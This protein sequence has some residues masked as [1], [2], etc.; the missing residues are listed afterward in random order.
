MLR[1][2]RDRLF[3]IKESCDLLIASSTTER[4]EQAKR[5]RVVANGLVKLLENIGEAAK[6]LSSEF[7]DSYP[8]I[9][10]RDFMRT[11]DRL[12]H[13]YFSIDMGRVW[14]IIE[15][16]VPILHRF[17]EDRFPDLEG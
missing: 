8:E 17:I 13:G 9:S 2:D 10:W 14:D 7:R 15:T 5:D 6:H 3:H 1:T 4:R 12:T 16:E 11:R